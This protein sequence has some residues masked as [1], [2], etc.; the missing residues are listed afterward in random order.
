MN[1]LGNT[2]L[3]ALFVS[4]TI[5]SQKI[6]DIA[7]LGD[8]QLLNSYIIYAVLLVLA[9]AIARYIA[10]LGNGLFLSKTMADL[11]NDY[12]ESILDKNYA[13]FSGP[14]SAKFISLLSNDIKSLESNY[15][16]VYPRMISSLM[17]LL[18]CFIALFSYNKALAFI[19]LLLYTPSILLAPSF[20]NKMSERS[21]ALLKSQEEKLTIFKDVLAG[22]SIIK[23]FEIVPPIKE[24]LSKSLAKEYD[25]NNQM[26]YTFA[27]ISCLGNLFAFSAKMIFIIL[28]AYLVIY[29]KISLGGVV[30]CV[31]LSN[32]FVDPATSLIEDHSTL[33]A[34]T[35]AIQRIED[36]M[37]NSVISGNPISPNN[38][39]LKLENI[40]FSYGDKPVLTNF[41]Y[42]FEEG[43]KYALVGISGSGKSTILNLISGMT[44]IQ[45]GSIQL[46]DILLQKGDNIL[47]FITYLNQQVFLFEDSYENNILLFKTYE[48]NKIEYALSQCGIDQLLEEKGET[49]KNQIQENGKNLSGGQKQKL[50]LA[51]VFLRTTPIILLD[52]VT[53]SIDKQSAI[54]LEKAIQQL[55]A[56]VIEVTHHLSEEMLAGYDEI[57]VIA[58]G[59]VIEHGNYPTLIQQRGYFYTMQQI[60]NPA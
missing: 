15:F 11:Q 20:N 57:L 19:N 53:S 54:D 41:S 36:Q 44:P 42:T 17:M 18:F 23:A 9:I 24:K 1:I 14:N 3:T 4:A 39:R 59:T 37:N 38:Y 60:S 5:L 28:V 6:I 33:K 16:S 55:P 12:F 43:K 21:A 51:R 25:C 34:S 30:A 7:S 48:N 40:H 27:E 49:L 8:I 58:N 13:E 47:P 31:Q 2:L 45:N 35:K 46:G 56:T 52:E 29:Q 32:Q 10:R 26:K 50:S 22:F